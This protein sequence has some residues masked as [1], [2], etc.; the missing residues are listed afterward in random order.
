MEGETFGAGLR[1]WRERRSLSLRALSNLAHYSKSQLSDLE[2]GV[3]PARPEVA[4]HLDTVLEAEGELAALAAAPHHPLPDAGLVNPSSYTDL[5]VQLLTMG[6]GQDAMDRRS[7]VLGL[8]GTTTLGFVAPGMALEAARH[9]LTLS[10]AE[11]RAEATIEEW[12]EIVWEYGYSYQHTAPAEL[13]DSLMVDVLGLQLLLSRDQR[14]AH[15]DQ[16]QRAGAVLAALTAMTIANL[17]D[18]R[19]ARRWWRSARQL[20]GQSGDVSADMWVRGREAIRGLYEGRPT[21]SILHLVDDTDLSSNQ[22]MPADRAELLAAKAQALAL[23][24]R[25]PEAEAALDEV[26]RAYDELPADITSEHDSIYGWAENRLRFTESF[27]YSH[28]GDSTKAGAAQD[29]AVAVY[30]ARYSRGPAQIELQRALCM[31]ADGDAIG[32]ADHATKTLESLVEGDQIRPIFSLSREV[33]GAIPT[34]EQTRPAVAE[35][36]DRL[37]LASAG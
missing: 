21:A 22:A 32:G 35:L 26:R 11:G 12:Q 7:F 34:R 23:A 5:A 15:L 14:P 10:L 36:R 18:V 24:G 37:A 13:L 20:A 16:L 9:G 28:L 27:V 25:Q 4:Q 3:R 17:G 29:R 8:G 2:R 33:L 19:Q 31:V 1:F 6:G 30:P